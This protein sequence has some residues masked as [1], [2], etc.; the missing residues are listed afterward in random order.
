MSKIQG[1]HYFEKSLHDKLKKYC[2]KQPYSIG[3][4]DVIVVALES[5]LLNDVDI[6]NMTETEAKKMYG[7][8]IDKRQQLEEQ[9]M[10]VYLRL[11]D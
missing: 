7:A 9:I 6:E 8:L 11:E 3:P 2:E 1:S 10:R 4:N 5:H